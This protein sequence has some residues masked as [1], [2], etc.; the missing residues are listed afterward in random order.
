M[1]T[2]EEYLQ[3]IK[4]RE[5]EATREE[6]EEAEK[7]RKEW[8]A[9]HDGIYPFY[10]TDLSVN[11]LSFDYS[12]EIMGMMMQDFINDVSDLVSKIK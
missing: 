1:K 6:R 5:Y 8:E 10:E 4:E 9:T 12:V 3:K 2:Y 7:R 11:K